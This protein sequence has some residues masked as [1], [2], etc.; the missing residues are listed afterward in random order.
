MPSL[1]GTR[2]AIQS[3]YSI[4]EQWLLDFFASLAMTRLHARGKSLPERRDQRAQ[5]RVVA[6]DAALFFLDLALM[7]RHVALGLLQRLRQMLGGGARRFWRIA[8]ERL[9]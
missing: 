9:M 7:I 2:E 8:V 5:M 4:Y 1:R 3:K 6:R